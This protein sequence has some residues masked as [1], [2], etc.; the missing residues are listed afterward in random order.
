MKFGLFSIPY[1]ILF[2]V[3]SSVGQASMFESCSVKK[4]MPCTTQDIISKL[5][6][7]H[8]CLSSEACVKLEACTQAQSE[9][10]R[11][12]HERKLRITA[13]VMKEV[14][15][16]KATTSC[17]VFIRKKLTSKSIDTPVGKI[18]KL[19]QKNLMW[20]IKTNMA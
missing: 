8:V 10:K 17:E 1:S 9:S 4:E 11:W 3:T 7:N 14:C 15:H 20:T 19:L 12:H 6:Q 18:M 2:K 13:S 5:Y 16:R